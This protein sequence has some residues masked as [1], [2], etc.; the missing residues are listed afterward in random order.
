MTE[1][2]NLSSF[3]QYVESNQPEEEEEEEVDDKKSVATET[4]DDVMTEE[5][6]MNDTR[7]AMIGNVDSGKSTLIG[8]L[9]NV[10]LDDGRGAARSTVLKHRHELENGR[11]STATIELMGYKGEEQMTSTA[12]NHA[13]RWMEVVEKSDRTVSLID[14]CGHEKYLKTTLFGLTGLMPDY[15]LLVVGANM[16]VQIM[17]REHVAIACALNIPMLVVYTK[18]DICPPDVLK[19]T[20]MTMA[21]LLQH[22]GKKP[23]PVKDLASV[24]VAVDSIVANRITPVFSVSSVTGIGM[25]LL[26]KLVSTIQRSYTRY[27]SIDTDADVCYE[28]MPTVYFPLDG[29]YEVRG[30]MGVIVGGTVLR[31]KVSVNDVLYLGPDKTGAFVQVTVRSIECRRSPISEARRGQS[32]TLSIKPVNRRITLR[33]A[34]FKKGM[35]AVDALPVPLGLP[36]GKAA[37][38]IA[39]IPRACREFDASVEILHHSTTIAPGYQP[40][41]HCGVLRQSAEITAIRGRDELRN[42][43]RA[44]VRFRLVYSPEYLL[45]GS[46]FLF[47]EGRAKGIGKVTRVYPLPPVLAASTGT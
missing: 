10:S 11:T 21:R 7:I 24:Q 37:A 3:F 39:A 14:L 23:F 5:Y 8:V 20:R 27:A 31:G 29:V 12:R 45:P 41:V 33:K 4:Y 30:V 2:K 36:G 44:E 34:W 16:G 47:R 17:T 9:T 1:Q 13:Q 46:A 28:R 22:H 18:V 35:V 32:A 42:G 38:E 6:E 19:S 43:D 25:D 15:C 26:R 40:L